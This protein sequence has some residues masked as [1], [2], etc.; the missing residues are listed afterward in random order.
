[1][2]NR[3]NG[4]K[5]EKRNVIKMAVMGGGG[6]G[7]SAITVKYVQQIFV[8]KYDPTIEDS[9]RTHREIDGEIYTLEILDTAG[10]EQFTAMRDLYMKNN[11]GFLL[12]YSIT[13]PASLDD[14]RGIYD[15]IIRVKYRKDFPL[16]LVGNKC[17]LEDDRMVEKET[18]DDMA[19]EWSCV[20]LEISAKE[21]INLEE[22][23]ISLVRLIKEEKIKKG[24]NMTTK[25]K[26]KCIIL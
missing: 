13:S 10:T 12:V 18:G 16:V 1:M 2:S 14:V 5:N 7:K 11:D 24:V 9:Y 20:F 17:D 4:K 22:A 15:Q 21:S 8:D 19:K 6:V 26:R 3:K 23:F 25:K